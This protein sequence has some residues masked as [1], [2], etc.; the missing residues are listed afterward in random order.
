MLL[1]KNGGSDAAVTNRLLLRRKRTLVYIYIY[2]YIYTSVLLYIYIIEDQ[3][4]REFGL[5]DQDI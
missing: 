5:I 3:H 2:I 4:L 1:Y